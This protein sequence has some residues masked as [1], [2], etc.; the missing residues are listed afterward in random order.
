MAAPG[1]AAAAPLSRA[2]AALPHLSLALSARVAFAEHPDEVRPMRGTH[3]TQHR[4]PPSHHPN[5]GMVGRLSPS[6]PPPSP[7][8][9][10]RAQ[11]RV[12]CAPLS[13]KR[14]TK[15]CDA[16]TWQF[17][18]MRSHC[19]V[20]GQTR[21]SSVGHLSLSTKRPEP[22]LPHGSPGENAWQR[23]H[24]PHADCHTC[25]QP[26]AATAQNRNHCPSIHS[27]PATPAAL[28][29][30]RRSRTRRAAA[31]AAAPPPRPTPPR[32]PAPSPQRQTPRPPHP[33]SHRS[34]RRCTQPK[35]AH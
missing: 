6:T 7:G 12:L 23:L 33:G 10:I 2:G 19:Q 21:Q 20:Y 24:A 27:S 32:S 34:Q 29:P 16:A 18:T 3:A 1:D 17:K 15:C 5:S 4:P 35:S 31:A 13:H 26:A 30:T 25:S 11:L 9:Q 14:T 8:P 22:S 28:M